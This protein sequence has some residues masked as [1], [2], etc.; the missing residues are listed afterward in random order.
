MLH[1]LFLLEIFCS[2]DIGTIPV[3]KEQG[4]LII[5]GYTDLDHCLLKGVKSGIL[6]GIGCPYMGI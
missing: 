3:G 5:G 1:V 4:T 6:A 2:L